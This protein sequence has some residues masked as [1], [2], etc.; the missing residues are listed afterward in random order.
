M[1][2]MMEMMEA[3]KSV[4]EEMSPEHL[5]AL[6]DVLDELI[7][8]SSEEAGKQVKSGMEGLQKVTVAAPNKEGL[9]KGLEKAQEVVDEVPAMEE[10]QEEPMAEKV[11]EKLAP[12]MEEEEDEGFFKPKK[13]KM[14]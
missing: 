9:E 10:E 7:A 13:K 3:K 4:G 6:R 12:K 14:L 5:K 1:K 11:M 2:K 8:M